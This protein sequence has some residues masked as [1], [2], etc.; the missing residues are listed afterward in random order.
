MKVSCYCQQYAADEQEHTHAAETHIPL[1]R[2]FSHKKC[3]ICL[4]RLA[5]CWTVSKGGYP[6]PVRSDRPHTPVVWFLNR[7]SV[8]KTDPSP[9]GLI[10]TDCPY[11]DGTHILALVF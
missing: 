5:Y 9:T 6:F 7:V 10:I 1:A 4:V 2:D 8:S 3:E 11:R